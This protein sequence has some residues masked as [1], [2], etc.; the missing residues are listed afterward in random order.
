LVKYTPNANFTG[1]SKFSFKVT[2]QGDHQD[3]NGV[4][5]I[6]VNSRTNGGGAGGDPYIQPVNGTLYKIPVDSNSY[7]MFDNLGI[8]KKGEEVIINAKMDLL[9]TGDK[10]I[11]DENRAKWEEY[12]NNNEKT[13]VTDAES[14]IRYLYINIEGQDHCIDLENLT[15]VE[16]PENMSLDKAVISRNTLISKK[17]LKD[18]VIKKDIEEKSKFWGKTF[19][20][21]KDVRGDSLKIGFN[22]KTHGAIVISIMSFTQL[23]EFRTSI[24]INSEKPINQSN[25]N[26]LLVAKTKKGQIKNFT[27]TSINKKMFFSNGGKVKED[28]ITLFTSIGMMEHSFRYVQ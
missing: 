17:E 3:V 12:M 8:A 6:V 22:T 19:P 27:N 7:R 14:F 13:Y 18:I 15:F 11:A 9:Y 28:K 4:F 24:Q 23:Q 25:A 16:Q 5:N 26:G 21:Y 1:W 10:E 20:I 2:H